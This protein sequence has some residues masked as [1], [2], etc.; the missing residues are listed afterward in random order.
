M[1]FDLENTKE[2]SKEW[3]SAPAFEGGKQKYLG[4]HSEGSSETSFW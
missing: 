4:D 1:G 3:R 2:L